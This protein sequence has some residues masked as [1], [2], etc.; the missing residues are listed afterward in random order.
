MLLG[1]GLQG[2]GR[3]LDGHQQHF[4]GRVA[5]E[6]RMPVRQLQNGDAKRP[7]VR[8][9]IVPATAQSVMSAR[10]RLISPLHSSLLKAVSAASTIY[11]AL[12]PSKGKT[13]PGLQEA[14]SADL[15]AAFQTGMQAFNAHPW[16]CSMTSGA[17]QQGVPTKVFREMFL[18]PQEPPRSI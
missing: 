17:I 8:R 9:G 15:H 13:H 3:V 10:Q 4:H 2:R 6:G 7:D 5:R 16:V 12:M 1:V 14:G 11:S 18:F